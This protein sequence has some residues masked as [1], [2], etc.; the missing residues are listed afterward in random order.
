MHSQSEFIMRHEIWRKKSTDGVSLASSWSRGMIRRIYQMTGKVDQA[1]W[2]PSLATCPNQDNLRR[3]QLGRH[4]FYPVASSVC[5][6]QQSFTENS[7]L[8]KSYP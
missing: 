1:G 8:A 2:M 7:C 3:S 6:R 5:Q 4:V